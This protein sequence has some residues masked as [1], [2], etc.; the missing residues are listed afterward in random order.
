MAVWLWTLIALLATPAMAAPGV[1]VTWKANP[2]KDI[3]GYELRY[4]TRS[5]KYPHIIPTTAKK[6]SATISGLAEGTRYH[7]VLVAYNTSGMRSAPSAEVTYKTPSSKVNHAPSGLILSPSTGGTIIAGETVAFKAAASD[8]DKGD[9]LVCRW[10]F[11]TG[12]GIPA[13]VG[14]APGA[15][16]FPKPG[17]YTVTFSVTDSEGLSDPTPDKRIIHVLPETDRIIPR[18][19]WEVSYVDS[20]ETVGYAASRSIDGDP[21]TFWHTEFRTAGNTKPPHDLQIRLDRARKIAGF[22][23]LPRQDKFDIG[24]I[25]SWRF[26]VSTDGRN[27]GA[28]VASGSFDGSKGEKEVTFAPKLGRY[29]RLVA[30]DDAGGSVHSNVAE[31][32]LI[33]APDVNRPPVAKRIKLQT[34]KN[35]SVAVRLK[36]SDPDDNPLTYRIVGQPKHGKLRGLAP[37]LTYKP[38]RGFKGVD[39]IRYRVTDGT[40]TSKTVTVKIRV[41][42]TK[43][44]SKNKKKS[45]V[46]REDDPPKKRSKAP[47]IS[48]LRIDGRKYRVL[49]VEKD[50]LKPGRR[51]LVQVSSDRLD[52]FSGKRHTTVLRD[53]KK[54]L[55]V[56]DN[57]PFTA[58]RKRHIRLKQISR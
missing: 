33:A 47:R 30:L 18:S 13:A 3:A 29:V 17:T 55:R 51:P 10:N 43:K 45:A 24:D 16:R 7:F 28:P 23:Y 42:A 48:T 11:G 1:K 21:S 9:Q 32:N 22:L 14:L 15:V 44:K 20:E 19:G 41:K 25:V 26:Y 37:K 6:R 54:V 35:K 27:W 31:L 4:G 38:K 40:N 56:R 57:T 36:A 50:T 49:T 2:E 8:P 53:D 46:V 5:G 58:G 12:S 39:K 52:W 34:K